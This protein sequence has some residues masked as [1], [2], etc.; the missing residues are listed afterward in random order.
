MLFEMYNQEVYLYAESRILSMLA[1]IH[2][3]CQHAGNVTIFFKSKRA[4]LE[5]FRTPWPFF[6]T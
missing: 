1:L 2:S 6:P 5:F 4:S 3:F